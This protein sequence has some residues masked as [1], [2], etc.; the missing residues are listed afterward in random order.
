M[1]ASEVV[2]E[3]FQINLQEFGRTL[4]D[5]RLWS[6][7]VEFSSHFRFSVIIHS[8]R[9]FWTWLWFS[10]SLLS[11]RQNLCSRWVLLGVFLNY[12]SIWNRYRFVISW[13]TVLRWCSMRIFSGL[14]NISLWCMQNMWRA[15][16]SV[17]LL[18]LLSHKFVERIY[19]F[20][21]YRLLLLMLC[22]VGKQ[23]ESIEWLHDKI[24]LVF[25]ILR[26]LLY[27]CIARCF[28]H[29]GIVTGFTNNV[30]VHRCLLWHWTEISNLRCHYYNIAL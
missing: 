12:W 26:W 17:N 1:V 22:S 21:A 29:L 23:I 14:V 2:V 5:S 25:K 20:N 18:G 6:V 11:W 30:I 15:L 28:E 4:F 9:K 16:N 7:F 24:W 19:F 3:H 13:N 8:V 10:D 27:L